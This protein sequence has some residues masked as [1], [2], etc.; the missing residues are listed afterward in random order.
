MVTAIAV[1]RM[2]DS[3]SR[4]DAAAG[5]A[6]RCTCAEAYRVIAVTAA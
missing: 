5:D 4:N 1:S 3:R 6:R 2:P